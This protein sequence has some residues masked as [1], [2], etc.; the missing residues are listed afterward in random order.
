MEKISNTLT[1]VDAIDAITRSKKI[2]VAYHGKI[3]ANLEIDKDRFI[4]L[5]KQKRVVEI[6][7]EQ[8]VPGLVWLEKLIVEPNVVDPKP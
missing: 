6:E 5:L 3:A 8:Y 4:E 2:R 1:G 7:I